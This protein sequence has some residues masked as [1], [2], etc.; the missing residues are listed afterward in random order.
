MTFDGIECVYIIG[1]DKIKLI[2]KNPDDI[3]KLS[4]HSD[5]HN[6]YFQYT[7]SVDKNQIAYI[8][9]IEM[10]MGHSLALIPKYSVKLFTK[11]PISSL[12]MTGPALD[13]FFSPSGYFYDKHVSGDESSVDLT[14]ETEVADKWEITVEGIMVS[15]SLLYGGILRRGKAS[16][17]ML[18]PIL[19]AEFPPS[20]VPDFYY[21]IYSIFTRFLQIAQYNGDLR[22]HK[23]YLRGAE[24]EYNSG[25]LHDWKA[26]NKENG[27]FFSESDYRYYKPYVQKLLQFSADNLN[28]SLEFL[29]ISQYRYQGSDY[30][31][32]LLTSLFAAFENEYRIN[33]KIYDLPNDTNI[34]SI[35]TR[36]LQKISE[37]D[38][39]ELTESEKIFLGQAQDRVNNLGSQTGQTRKVKNVCRVIEPVIKRSAEHLFIR[40]GLGTS[41]GFTIKEINRIAEKIV[42]LRAQAAH[43]LSLLSF[44]DEQAEYVLFLEILVYAQILKRAGI[45]DAGIELLIGV[46]FHC[47]IVYMENFN[48]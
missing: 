13:E 36:I 18:H 43:E 29:P 7:D 22:R 33:L 27:M 16:D 6:F 11:A 32:A 28:M 14:R 40:S 39:R 48:K 25:Y 30:S 45:D 20:V 42:A 38:T 35:K 9:K 26:C 31:P 17:L 37:C 34:D 15:I 3:R 5:D 1:A 10:N 47:N 2:P 41:D 8:E 23:V 4:R 19:C 21:K 12:E 46:V 24:P 44:D